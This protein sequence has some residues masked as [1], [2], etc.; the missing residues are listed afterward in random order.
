MTMPTDRPDH[1]I[2]Q[3]AALPAL[4]AGDTRVLFVRRWPL[5]EGHPLL[6]P[7]AFGVAAA[8]IAPDGTVTDL[9]F[10]WAGP[11]TRET[12]SGLIAD[13][14][15]LGVAGLVPN[16]GGGR[17]GALIPLSDILTGQ[18]DPLRDIAARPFRAGSL[19]HGTPVPWPAGPR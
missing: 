11:A 4:K 2:A 14:Q 5:A 17:S 8:D 9:P 13:A 3:V 1:R 16:L 12:A 7:Y 10:S 15:G 19:P 6:S 18:V